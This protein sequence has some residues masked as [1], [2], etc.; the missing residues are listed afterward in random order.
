MLPRR[1]AQIIQSVPAPATRAAQLGLTRKKFAKGLYSPRVFF[2]APL[3]K[4]GG[5]KKFFSGIRFFAPTLAA[6]CEILIHFF[7]IKFHGGQKTGA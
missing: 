3:A 7:K 6:R 1:T 4:I 2:A 5:K